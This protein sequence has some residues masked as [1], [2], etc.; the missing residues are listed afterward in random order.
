MEFFIATRFSNGNFFFPTEIRI[1]D[2]TITIVKPG[3]ISAMEKTMPLN[4]IS[5]VKV[6]SPIFGF[7]K[8]EVSAY[9]LDRFILD[10]FLRR[11]AEEVKRL[12]DKSLQT[13]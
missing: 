11:D 1:D 8:I 7:S 6:Y 13:K 12:L 3:L 4:K 5:S 2:N 9:G 10:G